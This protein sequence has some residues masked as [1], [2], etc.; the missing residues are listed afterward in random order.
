SFI[1]KY[2]ELQVIRIW[3][4]AIIVI[5]IV[6]LFFASQPYFFFRYLSIH[7]AIAIPFLTLI[8]VNYLNNKT[9]AFRK[10][11]TYLVLI[12]FALNAGYYLHYPKQISGLALRTSFISSNQLTEKKIGMAQS[13]ISGYF[14]D[15]VVNLDGKVNN[16]ALLAIKTNSLYEYIV[17]E[18]INILI[19]WREWFEKIDSIKLSGDWQ[20]SDKKVNDNKTSVFIEK[21]SEGSLSF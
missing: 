8:I 1:K 18:K 3:F 2:F 12:I 16:D 10:M 6:Y 19:A 13:G 20:V 4:A 21:S 5:S 9:P 11:F 14:F 7:I 17:K 15:N